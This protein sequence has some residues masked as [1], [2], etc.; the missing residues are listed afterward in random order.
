MD[1]SFRT[2]INSLA[3]PQSGGT[4]YIFWMLDNNPNVWG[5]TVKQMLNANE[6]SSSHVWK[7][8]WYFN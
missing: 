6:K 1:K 2:K 7:M 3:N 8:T 4:N 5:L